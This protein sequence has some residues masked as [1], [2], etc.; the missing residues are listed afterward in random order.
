MECFS[1]FTS[2]VLN[3]IEEKGNFLI[4]NHHRQ[5]LLIDVSSI[6][7]ITVTYLKQQK[8]LLLLPFYIATKYA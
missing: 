5:S 2:H 7:R 6:D 4:G 3:A 8:L 1:H